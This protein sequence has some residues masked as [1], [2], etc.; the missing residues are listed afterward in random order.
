MKKIVTITFHNANNYGAMLQTYALQKFLSKSY[1]TE[2]LN[3]DNKN[4]SKPYKIFSLSPKKFLKDVISYKKNK[5]RFNNFNSFR[6]NLVLSRKFNDITD[7]KENYPK[8]HV[9]IVGSDQI[10]NPNITGGLDDI[11]CLNFG[12]ND[13]K[14]ITYA[15][16][17]GTVSNIKI[18]EKSFIEKINGIN[19]ISVREKTLKEYIESITEKKVN[20][21]VDPTLL[22]TKQEWENLKIT[23]RIIKQKY[24]FV[25]SVSNANELLYDITNELSKITGYKIVYFDKYDLKNNYKYKKISGYEYGPVEF[26]NLLYNSEYV[27]TTS[28]H[29]LAMSAIFNKIFF[30]SLS[31]HPDR[32]LTLLETLELKNRIVTKKEDLNILMN[33]KID[34]NRVNNIINRERKKSI[35]WLFNS[36]ES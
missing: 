26:L 21:V 16:S 12:K 2:I 22:L 9:Y 14:K 11:Y 5:K 24:I 10:W 3:Y 4:I 35:E 13:F 17:C 20:V 7:I 1:E 33:N 19:N 8:A 30:I 34:W 31:S 18:C 23:D 32:L 29:G 15:A 25:Y 36:I 6:K 27:V 28:F